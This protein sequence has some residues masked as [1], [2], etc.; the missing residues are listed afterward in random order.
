MLPVIL[1][2]DKWE[3]NVSFEIIVYNTTFFSK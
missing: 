1:K 2:L 3:I